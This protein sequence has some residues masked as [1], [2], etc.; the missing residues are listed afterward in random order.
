MAEH[1]P[2]KTYSNVGQIPIPRERKTKFLDTQSSNDDSISS[3]TK[4]IIIE[5]ADVHQS[6]PPIPL[7]RK[8]ILSQ[9]N[10]SLGISSDSQSDEKQ[11]S[12]NNVIQ[13]I[14]M[15]TEVRA[16]ETSSNNNSDEK[17]TTDQFMEKKSSHILPKSIQSDDEDESSN[18]S[19]DDQIK[20]VSGPPKKSAISPSSLNVNTSIEIVNEK[21]VK[22]E[23]LAVLV[24]N[25]SSKDE[26]SISIDKTE[27]YSSNSDEYTTDDIELPKNSK[28][29]AKLKVDQSS[30][31]NLSSK[32]KKLEYNYEEII[33]NVEN[34]K[35]KKIF[36]MLLILNF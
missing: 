14:P 26:D 23:K 11:S 16:I 17:N 9:A 1:I 8:K 2:L 35:S 24:E 30:K 21:K 10:N 22:K 34:K 6:A 31:R 5:K 13:T 18:L 25:S 33:G 36:Q 12:T 20:K 19:I 28:Q 15:I 4:T 29:L 32:G 7:P 3:G 27:S